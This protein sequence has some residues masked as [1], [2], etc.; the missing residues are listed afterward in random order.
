MRAIADT[1]FLVALLNARDQHHDWARQ[2]AG[3]V[4]DALLT[5]EAVVTEA[6]YLLNNSGLV[7]RL[8]A[9]ELVTLS[10][11]LDDHIPEVQELATRYADRGPDLCDLCVVRMSELFADHEVITTDRRDFSVYRRHKRD[12]IPC[13]FPPE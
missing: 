11:D 6:A 3:Q 13:I 12:V 4:D 1:G 10:F 5:C 2:L 8:V 9:S 7:L